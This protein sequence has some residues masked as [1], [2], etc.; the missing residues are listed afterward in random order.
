LAIWGQWIH[1]DQVSKKF[2]LKYAGSPSLFE[3]KRPVP[4]NAGEGKLQILAADLAGNFGQHTLLF[5]M[6]P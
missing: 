4:E 2:T 1:G 5:H 3:G 6:A